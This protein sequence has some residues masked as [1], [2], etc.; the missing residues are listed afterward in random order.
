M[1]TAWAGTVGAWFLVAVAVAVAAC[2]KGGEV[3]PT[4]TPPPPA[5]ACKDIREN[6]GIAACEAA[7]TA[8]DVRACGV[9]GQLHIE[10]DDEAV[11]DANAAPLLIKACE[12]GDGHGCFWLAAFHRNGLGGLPKDEAKMKATYARAATQH[13]KAC[14][15]GDRVACAVGGDLYSGGDG[16]TVDDAKALALWK[17]GCA[18]GSPGAC[19][20]AKKAETPP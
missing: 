3:A 13:E 7:C 9:A 8:G 2:G 20:S 17:K 19:E 4:P 6:G 1:R 18:L 5:N 10:E 14:D 15:G 16:G 11:A 12:G